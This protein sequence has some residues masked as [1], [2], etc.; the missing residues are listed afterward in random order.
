VAWQLDWQNNSLL[1]VRLYTINRQF[2][3]GTAVIKYAGKEILQLLQTTMVRG[4]DS[5][6]MSPS[7]HKQGAV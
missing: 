4:S 2:S 5:Q 3:L 1:S 6:Q 7:Q